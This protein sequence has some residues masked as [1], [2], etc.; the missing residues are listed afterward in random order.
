MSD[1][2]TRIE[3][4]A[5]RLRAEW[6]AVPEEAR[7]IASEA[8]TEGVTALGTLRA[9]PDGVFTEVKGLI[10][11]GVM[12]WIK[13]FAKK[14]KKLDTFNRAVEQLPPEWRPVA[15]ELLSALAEETPVE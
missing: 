4:T 6:D 5:A 10:G 7:G 9:L 12:L 13:P 14:A 15:R 1:K 3:Q 2:L 8:L 11:D